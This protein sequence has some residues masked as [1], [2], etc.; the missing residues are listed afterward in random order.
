MILRISTP[1]RVWEGHKPSP[2]NKTTIK[3]LASKQKRGKAAKP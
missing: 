1:K 2:S 3:R